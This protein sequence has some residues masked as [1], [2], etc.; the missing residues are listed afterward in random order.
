[1]IRRAGK[2]SLAKALERFA[3]DTDIELKCAGVPAL[4]LQIERNTTTQLSAL[5]SRYAAGI[6][7]GIQ[8]LSLVPPELLL[9]CLEVAL[10]TGAASRFDLVAR[11]LAVATPHSPR[12]DIDT[13]NRLRQPVV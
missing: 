8:S 13:A 2:A 7:A 9:T 12:S 3:L 6:N 11:D 5:V 1:M 10:W 4:A